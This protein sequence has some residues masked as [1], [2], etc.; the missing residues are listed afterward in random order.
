M[1]SKLFIGEYTKEEIKSILAEDGYTNCFEFDG[2]IYNANSTLPYCLG[3]SDVILYHLAGFMTILEKR[4]ATQL[5]TRPIV[6][7]GITERID[8][9]NPLSSYL[10]QMKKYGRDIYIFASYNDEVTRGL[11]FDVR[12]VICYK[13]EEEA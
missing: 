2:S 12:G 8:E 13:D 10:L 11:F 5:D 1:T 6:L 3:M 9:N 4:Q 7:C